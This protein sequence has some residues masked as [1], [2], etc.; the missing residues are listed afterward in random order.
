MALAVGVTARPASLVSRSDF[1]RRWPTSF[2]A[3]MT[4]STGMTDRMPAIVISAAV[5]ATTVAKPLRLTHGTSTRP[6][7]GSQTSPMRF[8]MASAAPLPIIAGV[9][10]ASS[11]S[12]AAAM[13]AA[14]PHSAWQPPAAPAIEAF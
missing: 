9:P 3:A 8:L 11:T 4:S 1:G 2:I 14:V 10:P 5:M 7:T 13:P 6:A 12:A